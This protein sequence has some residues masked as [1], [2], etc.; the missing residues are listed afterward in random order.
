MQKIQQG[1][2]RPLQAN[3]W[4]LTMCVLSVMFYE[5]ISWPSMTVD[6]QCD[7]KTPLGYYCSIWHTL[8]LPLLWCFYQELLF[9]EDG[10]ILCPKVCC[11]TFQSTQNLALTQKSSSKPANLFA[12]DAPSFHAI[13][14]TTFLL[15][16]FQH[17]IM[18][19]WSFDSAIGLL[20]NTST[21]SRHAGIMCSGHVTQ[22]IRSVCWSGHTLTPSHGDSQYCINAQLASVSNHG[23]RR[24]LV[25]HQSWGEMWPCSVHTRVRRDNALNVSPLS[26]QHHHPSSPSNWQRGFGW[27]LA[28]KDLNCCNLLLCT[29][30][31]LC[32]QKWD[33]LYLHCTCYSCLAHS[34]QGTAVYSIRQKY[35]F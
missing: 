28:L 10:Q 31:H 23:I 8:V 13:Y 1:I 6:N 9:P 21:L 5:P 35:F 27:P 12:F 34:H 25:L 14:A 3:T 24:A 11:F 32:L 20:L 26:G 30:Y 4:T 17:I 29:C 16:F 2:F 18:E 22:W 15:G 7:H 33:L 19:G